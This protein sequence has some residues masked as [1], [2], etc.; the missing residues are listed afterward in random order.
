MGEPYHTPQQNAVD[1]EMKAELEAHRAGGGAIG[2]LMGGNGGGGS[3]E[4]NP[5][6]DF[7]MAAY[8]AGS[9]KKEGG[10]ASAPKSQGVRR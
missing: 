2:A 9:N 8:L 7:D 10:S 1:P 4:S 5:L 3:K 6:T